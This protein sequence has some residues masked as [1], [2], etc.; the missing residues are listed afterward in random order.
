[1]NSLLS[2]FKNTLTQSGVNWAVIFAAIVFT[3]FIDQLYPFVVQ[4]A[5]LPDT[6]ASWYYWKRPDPDSIS[7]FS[8]WGCYALHQVFLLWAIHKARSGNRVFHTSLQPRNWMMLAVT[9]LFIVLHWLQTAIWYD[10]LAQDVPVFS[11][12]VAVI[13]MLVMILIFE[14]RRRGLF[15]GIKSRGMETA[16]KLFAKYHAYFFSFAL[17]YTFWFHPM[18]NTWG[19]LIGFYY[20]ILILFQGALIYTKY[21]INRYWTVFL[22]VT[23]L[24]HGTLVAVEQGMGLSSMF[25][26]GFAG[27]F[28]V[29]QMHGL[30]WP[31]LLRVGLALAY[32]MGIVVVYEQ[33]GWNMIDEAFRIPVIMYLSAYVLS[34]LTWL[35]CRIVNAQRK[36]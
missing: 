34:L 18:E 1:M 2:S 4:V 29:T 12:Q 3:I 13:I 31:R 21:H 7:R 11:P 9:S 33:R 28:I 14:N 23:V 35:V 30:G 20:T 24:A 19:H 6:G 22:E 17:T 25:F 36:H 8:A 27:V 15:F 16:G 32:L 5:F 10:G 26:F